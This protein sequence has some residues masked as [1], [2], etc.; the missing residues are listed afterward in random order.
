MLYSG[1]SRLREDL[2]D[3]SVLRR[4]E[5][6]DYQ[7]GLMKTEDMTAY[8]G[9]L[10]KNAGSKKHLTEEQTI[11]FYVRK[12]ASV[13]RVLD[14]E[15][16]GDTW[17]YEKN[18]AFMLGAIEAGKTFILVTPK[19][20]YDKSYI[21]QTVDELLWLKDNGYTFTERDDGS[22]I[23]KPPAQ[24]QDPIMRNYLNGKGIYSELSMND[25]KDAILGFKPQ[26]YTPRFSSTPTQRTSIADSSNNWRSTSAADTS[27]N[28]R[29]QPSK[30][31]TV[32]SNNCGQQ[33]MD[34]ED[35]WKVVP[36]RGSKKPTQTF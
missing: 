13:G 28:W 12:P 29:S 23:C 9:T 14:P 1:A 4:T 36:K 16:R 24:T 19:G 10:K 34:V 35:G 25:K 15:R 26:V 31:D 33:A 8:I 17:S 6:A 27:V 18:K 11:A 32:A 5:S 2:T 21:T 3:L 20:I 22:M 7:E 30:T